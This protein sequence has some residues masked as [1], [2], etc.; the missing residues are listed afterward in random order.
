MNLF[1]LEI[2]GVIID[3][4]VLILILCG[5]LL[6]LSAAVGLLHFPTCLRDCTRRRSRRCSG[7]C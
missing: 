1:G 7:C 5:A 4:T 6:C 2:P 3:W